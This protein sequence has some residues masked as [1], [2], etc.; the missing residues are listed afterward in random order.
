[1]L[2]NRR[3]LALGAPMA[4]FATG[5]KGKVDPLPDAMVQSHP[6]PDSI[7]EVGILKAEK[8]GEAGV[9]ILFIPG[10]AGGPWIWTDMIRRLAPT[11][12]VYVLTLAGFDGR[13]TTTPPIIDK[14]VADIARLI[15]GNG[16]KKPLLVGH[17]LGG[18][19]GLR[20]AIEHSA[21]VGGL[22]TVEGFP[23]F[24]PL[25]E[26]SAEARRTA[27]EGLAK[28]FS[29][30]MEGEAFR[31][32]LEKFFAA[33]MNDPV[34]AREIAAHAARSDPA[35]IVQYIME[36]LPADLRPEL[37]KIS[38]P[39]L[40]IVA[41]NSYLI[42]RSEAE[43]RAFYAGLLSNAPH[44]SILLIRNARHFVMIDQPEVVGAAIEGFVDRLQLSNS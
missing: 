13:A 37:G 25:V 28:Q 29:P 10:L 41:L 42:G 5:G 39:F 30:S 14:A 40:S 26:M 18:F 7:L 2:L 32:A 36:M 3:A 11:H 6:Q 20:L 16:F 19:I 4:L 23:V 15:S 34:Q 12:A 9:P 38:V 17:S 43:T 31:A 44:V 35:A 21:L 24:P 1:M 27:A 22:V 33:R 8:H